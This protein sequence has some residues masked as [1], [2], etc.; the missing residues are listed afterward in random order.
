MLDSTFKTKVTLRKPKRGGRDVNNEVVYEEFRGKGEC[1]VDIRCRFERRRR[2][3]ISLE[4]VEFESDATMIYRKDRVPTK[5]GREDLIVEGGDSFA[6]A[7]AEDLQLMFG[8]ARYE[9]LTLVFS[10]QQVTKDVPRG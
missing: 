5:I 3:A 2:R 10:R 4:G 1:L 8:T 9:R 6:I 7:L